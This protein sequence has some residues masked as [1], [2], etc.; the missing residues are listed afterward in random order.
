MSFLSNS[1]HMI[2]HGDIADWAKYTIGYIKRRIGTPLT[3][4][5]ADAAITDIEGVKHTIQTAA[6][7][8]LT[9]KL[10]PIG[11]PLAAS[12]ADAALNA[13]AGQIEA[14]TRALEASAPST[15]APPVQ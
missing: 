5:M 13:I 1:L 8:F 10:G 4:V 6:D 14:A 15:P 7:A 9:A 12:V 3:P 2:E 11:G